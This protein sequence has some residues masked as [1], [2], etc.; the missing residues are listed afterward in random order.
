M[1]PASQIATVYPDRAPERLALTAY[2]L[3]LG[4]RSR[5]GA[6]PVRHDP[7]ALLRFHDTACGALP[8]EGMAELVETI[9]RCA[10]CPLKCSPPADRSIC[11]EECLLLSLLS[12]IQ[13]G[14][15]ETVFASALGLAG[16]QGALDVI[17]AGGSFAIALKQASQILLPVPAE[18][19]WKIVKSPSHAPTRKRQLN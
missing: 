16:P 2:R 14:D 3:A 8:V 12:G 13:H 7:A 1:T 9:G 10:G 5:T 18:T 11:R 15:D 19:I 6:P 17:A 4:S